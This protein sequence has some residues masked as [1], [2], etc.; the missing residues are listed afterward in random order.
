MPVH[1]DEAWIESIRKN[2]P[3]PAYE[4]YERMTTKLGLPTHDSKII[5]SNQNLSRLFDETLSCFNKPKDVS[6]WI[7]GEI[8]SIAKDSEIKDDDIKI[9]AKKLAKIAEL[10][11]NNVINRSIGK[12]VLVKVFEKDIDP[13]EYIAEQ[14]LVMVNDTGLLEKAICEV[15]SENEKT[16]EEYRNGSKK[17]FGFL[18][19]QVMKKTEGKADP[20]TVNDLLGKL[21]NS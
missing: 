7:I 5:S 16:V 10:V 21:I 19:G 12:K 4:K 18:V 1:I 2:L 13:E 11:D 17:V 15:L 14:S 6:N 20:R 9:D 8:L 3:E